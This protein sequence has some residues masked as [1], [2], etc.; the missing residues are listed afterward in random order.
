VSIT[1]LIIIVTCI[2]SYYAGLT[3]QDKMSRQGVFDQLKHYPVAEKRNKE[4]YRFLSSGFVH[5]SWMHLVINM[6]VL[7]TF[8]ETI[9]FRFVEIFGSFGRIAF[10]LMY[11]AAIVIADIP[12]YVKHQN[13]PGFASIGAS[14]AVSAVV[15]IF[16]MFY[17]WHGLTF[18]FFPFFSFPA[19]V[20]GIGYLIYSSWASNKGRDNIDHSAHFAG[21]IFGIIFIVVSHPQVVGQFLAQIQSNLPF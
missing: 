16:I 12:S 2:V 10:L 17:P 13:N 4:Y 6:Y 15:F 20:L 11:L 9:E 18:I 21:A 19:I 14:G 5:G 7:Y 3:P 8:G 1:I